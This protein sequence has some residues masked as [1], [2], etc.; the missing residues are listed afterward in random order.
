MYN[1]SARAYRANVRRG[2]AFARQNMSHRRGALVPAMSEI[3]RRGSIGVRIGRLHPVI[4]AAVAM[5]RG[6]R[7]HFGMGTFCIIIS[8]HRFRK[9]SSAT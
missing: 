6:G 7:R 5:R 2:G 4:K 3:F 1:I 9:A 8:H